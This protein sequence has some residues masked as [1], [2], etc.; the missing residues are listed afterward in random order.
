MACSMHYVLDEKPQRLF[1]FTYLK[2]SLYQV[3]E[4]YPPTRLMF[5][6]T[7]FQEEPKHVR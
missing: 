2:L 6:S 4:F 5:C 1:K 3:K 7:H